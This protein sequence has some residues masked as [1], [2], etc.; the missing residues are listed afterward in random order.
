MLVVFLT[1]LHRS[2]SKTEPTFQPCCR[3]CMCFR[4]E[5]GGLSHVVSVRSS[6]SDTLHVC[7]KRLTS[8]IDIGSKFLCRCI[9]RMGAIL[10]EVG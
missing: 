2:D 5:S 10:Q 9:P 1:H 4:R 3:L 7:G 8:D 6:G